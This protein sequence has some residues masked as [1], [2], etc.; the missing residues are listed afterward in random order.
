ME[1]LAFAVLVLGGS[2][3][4]VRGLRRQG[5]YLEVPTLVS[6]VFLCWVVPQLWQIRQGVVDQGALAVLEGFCLLCL[7]ATVVGWRQGLGAALGKPARDPLTDDDLERIA[8]MCTAIGWT[9]SLAIGAHSLAERAS[10]MWSGPLTILYFFSSLKVVALFLSAYLALKR[11]TARAILLLAANLVLYAPVILVAFRRRAML[12]VF[13]CAVLAL[14]FA[15]R[16]LLPRAVI[17]AAM[18][19]GML[20]VFAVGELRA[21]TA[22]GPDAE[23]SFAAVSDLM[24]VDYWAQTPFADAHSAPEMTTAY[25]IVRLGLNS[26]THTFGTATWDRL[27]FQWVPAQIVGADIKQ[28]LMFDVSVADTILVAYGVASRIGAAPTAVGEAYLEFGLLGAVFFAVTAW[29]MG[30]WW[31]HAHRGSRLALALYAA[32]LAPAVL[33][34]TAYAGYFFNVMLLYGGAIVGLAAICRG[35]RRRPGR[36]TTQGPWRAATRR[37]PRPL[38]GLR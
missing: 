32:G 38:E 35:Q 15:R 2:I 14:W 3:V 28:A 21:I 8:L 10:S 17:L 27:V 9:M 5:G 33:M 29:I 26:A 19:V 13:T 34:P 22:G 12:E 18:P 20:A 24:A 11:R 7:V 16:I 37:L 36:A 23:P 6:A 30:R 25:N 1:P 4:L 31:V